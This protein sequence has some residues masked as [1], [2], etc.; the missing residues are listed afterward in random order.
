MNRKPD[1]PGAETL[2]E[3]LLK[4][5]REARYPGGWVD[6]SKP[7]PDSISLK[8][9][10][11]LPK[12]FFGAPN[13]EPVNDTLKIH[14]QRITSMI[15]PSHGFP[16]GS[17]LHMGG[18]QYEKALETES[19][20]PMASDNPVSREEIDAKIDAMTSRVEASEARVSTSLETLRG[21]LNVQLSKL[22]ANIEHVNE[23]QK[24]TATLGQVVATTVTTAVAIIGIMVAI[25]AFGA[26]RFS[27]G[28][29][30]ASVGAQQ[31]VDAKALSEENA[32]AL[33]DLTRIASEQQLQLQKQAQQLDSV[34]ERLPAN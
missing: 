6:Y 19:K 25:L 22:S 10:H 7:D 30:A 20:E 17:P 27:G 8:I 1:Q 24:R 23:N 4:A 18:A 3:K 21:D 14:T 31:A 12:A 13:L 9:A 11:V 15:K 34:L 5:Q 16:G 29:S 33:S 32:K 26:D 2:E 28:V